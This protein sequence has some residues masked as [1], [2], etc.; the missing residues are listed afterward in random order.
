MAMRNILVDLKKEQRY[1]LDSSCS[2]PEAKFC[3]HSIEHLKYIEMQC[4]QVIISATERTI[5]QGVLV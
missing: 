5:L 1:W 3:E 2:D 4:Q